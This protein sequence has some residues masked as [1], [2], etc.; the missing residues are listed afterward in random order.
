MPSEH[1]PTVSSLEYSRVSK[2][3]DLLWAILKTCPGC[4][5]FVKGVV[6]GCGYQRH[7]DLSGHCNQYESEK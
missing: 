5:R 1:M 7:I 6:N 4:R 3:N 2:E